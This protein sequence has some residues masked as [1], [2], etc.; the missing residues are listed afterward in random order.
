MQKPYFL[1]SYRQKARFE[2]RPSTFLMHSLPVSIY[3]QRQNRNGNRKLPF[4]KSVNIKM[5]LYILSLGMESTDPGECWQIV[6][7]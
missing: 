4:P 7:N 6:D 5:S 2:E 1:C 3:E